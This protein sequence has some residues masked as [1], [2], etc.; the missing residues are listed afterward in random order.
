M[1][2][3]AELFKFG[4][5]LL[6][7]VN[8]IGGVPTFLAATEGWTDE[9]RHRTARVTALTV[10]GVL[11]AS[12]LF[13]TAILNIFGI[14]IPA[15][16]IGGGILLLMLAISM[17]QARESHIRQTPEEAREASD[18]DAV[19]AVPLGIPLLA[20][21]GAIS[22]V[23]IAAHQSDSFTGHLQ[24]LIPIGVV[25][26]AAWATFFVAIRV[27]RRLGTTGINIITRLMGLILAAVAVE[28]VYRGLIQLFPRLV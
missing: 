22:S 28:F 26:V 27:A 23:I 9:A 11:A 16:Q 18:K 5:T 25:A 8:P 12:S 1:N 2:D 7:I 6:A 19:G 13:G 15:F 3:T 24:M 17:L 10:F 20:G 21:P 14:G 4:V